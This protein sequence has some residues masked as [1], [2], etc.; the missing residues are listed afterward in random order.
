[1]PTI[2]IISLDSEK[3]EINQADYDFAIIK[4]NKLISHRGLFYDFL[5][6]F[7]GAI[8][9][10]GN[11]DFIND[12][13]G[14]FFGGDL[15]DCEHDNNKFKF[16]DKYQNSIFELIST[17]FENSKTEQAIFLTDIQANEPKPRFKRIDSVAGFIKEH[18]NFGLN[19]NTAYLIN[20][21][22]L[23]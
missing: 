21:N 19:W 15:I 11:P 16:S 14:E 10:L 23:F 4:E 20:P 13:K 5:L 9:H 17:A 3:F 6:K 18:D 1:M 12:K 8:I 7:S 22:K 2:E